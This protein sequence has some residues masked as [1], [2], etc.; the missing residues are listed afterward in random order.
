MKK[1]LIV[2]G[3]LFFLVIS[4]KGQLESGIKDI[5]VEEME[6]LLKIDDVQLVDVRTPE[7]YNTGYIANAQNIDY[8]S[9]TI[10]EDILKLDKKK[11]VILYC[12][13]GKRSRD[14]SEKLLTA[15]F[16]K[17]YNLEGGITQWEHEGKEITNK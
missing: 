9:P 7:E 17:I 15:G 4:C 10:D 2:F 3:L 5:T 1:L 6:S 16:K 8:Y 12:R 11:P 14:C 13:S